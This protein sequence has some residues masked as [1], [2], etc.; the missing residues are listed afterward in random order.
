ME[1]FMNKDNEV[2]P[3][4]WLDWDSSMVIN[5]SKVAAVYMRVSTS[6]QEEEGT[7]ENQWIELKERII[8]DKVSLP[9][10]NIYEDNGWSGTILNRP[11]LEAL[12]AGA[13]EHKFEILYI[14]YRG[15]LS[16]NHIHQ[17]LLIDE[18]MKKGVQIREIK[19][20]S[21]CSSEE[22]MLGSI[23]GMFHDYERTKITERMNLGKKRIVKENHELLGYVPCYGYDLQR[24]DRATKQRACFT[25]NEE[26]ARVVRNIFDMYA[27]GKSISEII[28]T[29]RQDG[30]KSPKSK[31]GLWNSG[32]IRHMLANT[33]YVG[34]HYYRKCK[35]VEVKKPRK[36]TEYSKVAIGSLE[37][38][39]KDEWWKVKG[40]PAIVDKEVFN[41]VQILLKKSA[42]LQPRNTKTH[43]YLLAGLIKCE[44]GEHRTGDP[45]G[46]NAYYR[47]KDRENKSE[48]VCFSKGINVEVFD[49]QVWNT[50]RNLLTQPKLIKKFTE[51]LI[52]N[53]RADNTKELEKIRK[54]IKKLESEYDRYVDI[55]GKG[56]ITEDK[57][58]EKADQIKDSKLSL[59][60]KEMEYKKLDFI[61]GDI[62]PEKI[63]KNLSKILIDGLPFDKKQKIIRM[64]IDEVVASPKEATIVGKIPVY[65]DNCVLDIAQTNANYFTFANISLKNSCLAAYRQYQCCKHGAYY[66]NHPNRPIQPASRIHAHQHQSQHQTT[67]RQ[68][69]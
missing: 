56:L 60:V 23:L 39:P 27:N 30:I 28:D 33:T 1:I 3:P 48:R 21:G 14:Y 41:K 5:S 59:E 38:R 29:L 11:G 16:R 32:T 17:E 26:Q 13:A 49:N 53:G 7:I 68:Q 52:V 2:T 45:A 31:N 6:E 51:H 8:R 35:A 37:K 22:L 62:E 67:H 46:V 18:L 63:A 50:I 9:K 66:A 65:D 25:I 34:E 43:N 44:C 40:I 64:V 19:G 10:E 55:F 36:N 54:Q 61:K 15:R 4:D 20:I 57:L 12:R 58:K 47:C 69:S 42:R 24:T